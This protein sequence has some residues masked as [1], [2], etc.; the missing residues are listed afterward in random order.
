MRIEMNIP[1]QLN[2]ALQERLALDQKYSIKYIRQEVFFF[3][4]LYFK[5]CSKNV[6]IKLCLKTRQL[7]SNIL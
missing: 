4:F 1:G 3:F 6:K 5:Q 7:I 2:F